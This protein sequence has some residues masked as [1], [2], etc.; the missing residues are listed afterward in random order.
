MGDVLK[1]E[2]ALVPAL[3]PDLMDWHGANG[4]HFRR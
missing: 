2:P 4:D 3:I 1:L